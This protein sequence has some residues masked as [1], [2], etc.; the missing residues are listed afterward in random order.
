M[1]SAAAVAGLGAR[2]WPLD[3]APSPTTPTAIDDALRE[4]SV[5]S[6]DRNPGQPRRTFDEESL[7][8][9]PPRSAALGVLQPVLVREVGAEQYQLIAGE[10][11]WRAAQRAGPGHHARLIRRADDLASP[12]RR[13][14]RTS[15]G[16]GPH[17]AR[18]GGRLRNSCS[19]TSASPTS[20][21]AARVG[22]S[23]ST[24]T[25]TVRL[26]QLPPAVQRIVP[27]VG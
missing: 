14:S 22:K 10:R 24:V 2:A 25:N 7:A 19:R 12:S 15:T 26:L 11:R 13:W 21:V 18:G 17:R 23:R 20:E 3:P 16:P 5:T 4:V 6:I 27:T 8:S 1:A 9:S